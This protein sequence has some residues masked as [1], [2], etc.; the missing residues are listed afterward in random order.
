MDRLLTWL[1]M[2]AREGSTWVG[3]AMIAVAVG[4]DPM[5][6]MH[7]AQAISFIVGGGLIAVGP[8]PAPPTER[9]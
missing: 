3:L 1:A 6:A 2:R 7:L 5:K 9:R 4:S 8:T